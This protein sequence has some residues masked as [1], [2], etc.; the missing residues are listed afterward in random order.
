MK[1]F[2]EFVEAQSIDP[3]LEDLT[4]ALFE[5]DSNPWEELRSYC[6]GINPYLELVYTEEINR[7]NKAFAALQEGEID[8]GIFGNVANW[9]SNAWDRAKNSTLGRAVGGVAQGMG[10]AADYAGRVAGAAATGTGRW[11]K[12][13]AQ[14][15]F[16]PEK[17]FQDAFFAVQALQQ[18]LNNPEVQQLSQSG[19]LT[20]DT[21][22][23]K[24][25]ALAFFKNVADTMQANRD[26]LAQAM[27]PQR[28]AARVKD[29][30]Q[31]VAGDPRM[32]GTRAANATVQPG[33]VPIPQAAPGAAP[34]AGA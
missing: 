3:I 10:G 22:Q 12:Q 18:A 6:R 28:D 5:M 29:L 24:M 19:K 21:P 17:K 15:M 31:T 16:G 9:A 33:A 2:N 7:Y 30:Q 20:M 13:T 25:D 11:A 4:L 27:A 1:T 34:A 32:R 14:N 26:K 8:E 23:G